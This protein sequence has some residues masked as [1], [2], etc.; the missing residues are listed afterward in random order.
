M[1]PIHHVAYGDGTRIA[2]GGFT[3]VV[4][5]PAE[6]T[7]G[8]VAI[9]EH[10]LEPGL[11]GAPLHRHSR[12]DETSIVMEGRLTVQVGNAVVQVGMGETI[13]KPRGVFHTF[14]NAGTRPARFIEVISPGGFESYFAELHRVIPRDGTPPDMDALVALAARYGME[15]DLSSIPKLLERHRLRLG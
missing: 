7:G 11:L 14:W 5:V 13:V 1:T 6:A 15:L 4:K 3:T 9:V 8:S 10:T 12:E 2:I